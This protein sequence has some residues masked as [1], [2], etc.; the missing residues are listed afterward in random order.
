MDGSHLP[1]PMCMLSVGQTRHFVAEHMVGKV[2]F[3]NA[4]STFC[5][6][7]GWLQAVIKFFLPIS[8][9]VLSVYR[10]DVYMF[11]V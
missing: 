6:A 1:S 11:R 4:G 8:A 3:A 7:Q 5:G 10:R 9:E 2:H